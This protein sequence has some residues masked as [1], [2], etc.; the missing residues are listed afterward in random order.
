MAGEPETIPPNELR[1]TGSLPATNDASA[2][3]EPLRSVHTSTFPQI[4]N[5]RGISVLV[6]T[7]QAGRLVVLRADLNVLNTHFRGF[8]KPM[9]V[10]VRGNRLAIGTAMEICEFHNLPAVAPKAPPA[11][12]HDACFMPRSTYATG[13]IQIHEMGLGG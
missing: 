1:A 3:L 7:Y 9:G 6:S 5:Q 12:K 10:A 13:D 2:Q 4:L 8:P 11:G